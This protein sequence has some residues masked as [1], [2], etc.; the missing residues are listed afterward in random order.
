MLLVAGVARARH[1]RMTPQEETL[2][3]IDKLNVVRPQ[4]PAV[5]QVDHSACIQMVHRKRTR[6]TTDC[7]PWKCQTD[8]ARPVFVLPQEEHLT[9]ASDCVN[10]RVV[11]HRRRV[12]VGHDATIG[13]QHG[14]AAISGMGPAEKS[15]FR[16]SVS[17]AAACPCDSSGVRARLRH[18]D[19]H[20]PRGTIP[21]NRAAQADIEACGRSEAESLL[22]APHIQLAPRLAVRL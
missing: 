5:T 20:L 12:V 6:N 15:S 11:T 4:I 21:L 2:F 8:A 19:G 3:G 13:K 17:R 10:D 9:L 1:Q 18:S 22:C 14:L 7:T 16:L